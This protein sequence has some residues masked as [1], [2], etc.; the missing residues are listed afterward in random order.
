MTPTSIAGDNPRSSGDG[1]LASARTRRDA[2]LLA[3]LGIGVMAAYL[4]LER[5]QIDVWD[6]KSMASVAQN[7]LQHGSLKQCCRAYG[8]FP[9][10]PGPY[11]KFGIG[12]S[13]MLV[14]LWHFQL[15]SNP[16]G[17]TF[18]GVANPLL[19]AAATVVIAKTGM[20]LG[21]RR[22]SAVLAALAFAFLTMAPLYSSEFFA[23]PGVALGSTLMLL[24]LVLWD[25]KRPRGALVIGIGAAIAILFRPD[26]LVLLGPIVALM[27][28]FRGYRELIATWRSWI[29]RLGIPL[30]LAL[31]WTL[32]YDQLRY[33]N[34]FQVGYSGAYD[35]R[36]FSNPL[37]QG[38]R[39]LL[40]SH[41]KSFFVFSPILLLAIPGLFLLARRRRS[42]AVVIVAMFVL[43][44]VFYARWWTPEGGNSW[45]P[46]FLLP[47]CAVLAIPL[48]E[49]FEWLHTVARRVRWPAIVVVAALAATSAVVQVASVLVSY[50][51]IFAEIGDVKTLPKAIQHATVDQRLD[52]YRWS[53]GGNQIMWNLKR[54]GSR[55]VHMPLYWFQHRASPFG[56]GMLLLAAIGCVAAICVAVLSDRIEQGRRR[57]AVGIAGADR[58]LGET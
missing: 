7:L 27:M 8:A 51:D 49:V 2:V 13:L 58:R 10:D 45:G 57:L 25:E 41:G 23:E 20:V 38:V 46:R 44:V 48:G 21:W 50:R 4:A 55:E 5:G 43:R 53:F 56:V 19:L 6:G 40:V 35:K 34:L 28:L 52:K 36:G 37:G 29:L 22:S 24:G 18:L 1:R 47:L 14:P 12:Y 26:S 39:L 54:I 30:G 31:A 32:F 33:G 16:A 15:T 11:A 3:L 9:R 17:A 42:L